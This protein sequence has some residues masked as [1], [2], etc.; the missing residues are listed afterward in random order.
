MSCTDGGL[1]KAFVPGEKPLW[2]LLRPPLARNVS[3]DT[4]FAA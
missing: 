4:R 3:A 1:N 2:T